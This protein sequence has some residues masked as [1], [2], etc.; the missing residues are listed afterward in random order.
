MTKLLIL[1][2]LQ[3]FQKGADKDQ[4]NGIP[5]KKSPAAKTSSESSACRRKSLK[6]SSSTGLQQNKESEKLVDGKG[7]KEEVILV[8]CTWSREES[9][10]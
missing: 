5:N 8:L 4:Q 6:S 9:A 1:S 2:L 7:N 3:T 10:L